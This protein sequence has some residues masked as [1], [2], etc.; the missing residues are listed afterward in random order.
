[1]IEAGDLLADRAYTQLSTAI[2]RN[3]LPPGTSLSVP[4][5]ARRLGISRSPVREAVQRLIWDGLADY[6]GR[7]GTVVV[8]IDLSDFLRLLE[9][10][11]VLEA[12][13]ARLAAE[14]G[15]DAQRDDLRQ[16][17]QEF[18]SLKS[19]DASQWAFLEIDMR[20]HAAIRAMSHNQD[21]DT[22]LAR[23]Q[24]RAHLSL[25]TLWRR[26][27]N[28]RVTQREHAAICE[29]IVDGD[30]DRAESA[31]R[32]HIA[33]LGQRVLAMWEDHDRADAS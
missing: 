4:E 29:A 1:M 19:S 28:L 30:T 20:F 13:A 18:E 10:R 2:L 9:V 25:N 3:E 16:I 27:R 26:E 5:L 33:C 11:E 6:R 31:A 8:D 12:L 7:R 14:R 32:T 23:S 21:L 17:H 22:T 15:S 24:G